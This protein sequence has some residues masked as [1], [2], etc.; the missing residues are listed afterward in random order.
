MSPFLPP[1]AGR[2]RRFF[3]PLS[4]LW[5]PFLCVPLQAK[6]AGLTAIEIYPGPSG[7]N[8][9]QIADY[10]LG[11]K[12]ELLLCGGATTGIDK[13]VYHRL[14]KVVLSTG[15]T[16]ERTSDGILMLTQPDDQPA[17]VV[18]ANLKFDKGGS[19]S[20]S[21]L[22]DKTD[23]AGSVVSGSDASTTQ[24]APL[25]P[26]VKI[27]FVAAP[28][29]ELAEYLR[30]DRAATLAGW[31]VY[32]AAFPAG[33]H[34]AQASKSM[35]ALYMQAANAALAAYLTAKAANTPDTPSSP[36]RARPTTRRTRW[37]QT[38]PPSPI[39]ARGFT[40]RSLP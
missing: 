13:N 16:L 11:G 26:G 33:A 34:L 6:N 30:A 1:C 38:T 17:C 40:R 29:K 2:L 5:L 25:K 18:P 27:V 3:L 8:Y 39:S 7:Q 23:I 32:F 12:N 14:A 19:F 21:D 10:V 4:L 28:D 15:M 24:I 35:A 36:P 31:Q 20:A 22:V 9:Q 37:W